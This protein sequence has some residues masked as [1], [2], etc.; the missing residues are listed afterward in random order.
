MFGSLFRGWFG[1]RHRALPHIVLIAALVCLSGPTLAGTHGVMDG[2]VTQ[3]SPRLWQRRKPE[4]PRPIVF[5]AAGLGYPELANARLGL[6]VLPRVTLE[7]VYGWVQ[8]SHMVG[9]G[10]TAH[11]FGESRRDAPPLNSFTLS[12]YLRNNVA[13]QFGIESSREHLGIAGEVGAGY[14]Y[15]ADYGLLA[16]A[17]V[18]VMASPDRHGAEMIPL[19][20][21]SAGWTFPFGQ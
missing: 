9:G 11:L 14:A 15:H 16:R 12:L 10:L 6:Y 13:R 4:P 2:P 8:S 17:E 20:R 21:V 5:A 1:V 3:T 7:G 18:V 19:L